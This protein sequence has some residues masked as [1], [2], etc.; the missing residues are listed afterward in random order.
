M[1]RLFL[2][3]YCC[4]M[5]SLSAQREMK[6]S[7]LSTDYF[8]VDVESGSAK[9]FAVKYKSACIAYHKKSKEFL[10]YGDGDGT[11]I[12]FL[13]KIPNV[14]LRFYP[15]KFVSCN[16]KDGKV[17]LSSQ[18]P[19]KAT[20]V[21]GVFNW[22]NEHLVWEKEETYDLSE[23]QVLR[24]ATLLKDGNVLGALATYDSVQYSE[25]YFDAQKVGIELLL[26][27][28]KTIEDNFGKRK[29]KESADLI[30]K[31]LAFKGMKWLVDLKGETELKTMLGKGLN[32]LTYAHLQGYVEAYTK[33]LL[34][35]KLYD[36]AIE[37]VNTYWKYFTNSADLML[38]YADAQYAKK[39]K[40]K[41]SEFYVKYTNAMKQAKKEK[42]IPYYVPQRIIKE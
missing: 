19:N 26:A 15:E 28:Q 38:N 12:I 25:S 8:L 22:Q 36:K 33:N 20:V 31:I 6:K 17:Y 23:Q 29:F 27:S 10:L 5:L 41:A 30:E 3:I 1:K 14:P 32:G 37:K 39:D 13:E 2:F 11:M 24:A 40:L 35:A 7:E 4:G 42:D 16:Y 34:E 18:I 9:M 21:T